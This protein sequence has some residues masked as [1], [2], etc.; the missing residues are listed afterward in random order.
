MIML[1]RVAGCRL[2]TRQSPDRREEILDR[3]TR[4]VPCLPPVGAAKSRSRTVRATHCDGAVCMVDEVVADAA[5][6]RTTHLAH[7]TRA[8]HDHDG[9]LLLGDATDHLAGLAGRRAQDPRELQQHSVT[10]GSTNETAA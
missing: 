1:F 2:R 3:V 6:D 9:L 8:R 10:H 4:R 5:E 7:A